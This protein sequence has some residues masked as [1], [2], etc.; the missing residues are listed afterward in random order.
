[1]CVYIYIYTTKVAEERTEKENLETR[2][3]IN[4]ITSFPCHKFHRGNQIFL[5]M[6]IKTN[7]SIDI[8]K[9]HYVSNW[10]S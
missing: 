2:A 8:T 5:C 6:C 4:V 10:V 1:M 3:K 7:Q 9:T